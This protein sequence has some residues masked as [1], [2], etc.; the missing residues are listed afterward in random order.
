MMT[1]SLT[2][3]AITAVAAVAAAPIEQPIPVPVRRSR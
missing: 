3:L 2:V 1:L